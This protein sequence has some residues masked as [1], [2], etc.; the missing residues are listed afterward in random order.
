MLAFR[1]ETKKKATPKRFSVT[2]HLP[3]SVE[4]SPRTTKNAVKFDIRKGKEKIGTLY[5]SS[6][7]VE[8]WPKSNKVNAWRGSWWTFAK[9][10]EDNFARRRST[11][12]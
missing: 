5:I 3:Y 11:R 10:L 8:W 9:I 2:T 1:H 6:G 7:T 12:G 4:L